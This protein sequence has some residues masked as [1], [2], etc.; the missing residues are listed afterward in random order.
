MNILIIIFF[1]LLYDIL[2]S[3]YHHDYVNENENNILKITGLILYT[4]IG[5]FIF[6]Y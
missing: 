2:D 6:Y 1:I 3:L 4:I 5:L